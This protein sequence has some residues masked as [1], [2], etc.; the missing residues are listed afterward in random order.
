MGFLVA[1][2][3]HSMKLFLALSVIFSVNFVISEHF[4]TIYLNH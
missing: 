2:I 4:T 1:L 3:T